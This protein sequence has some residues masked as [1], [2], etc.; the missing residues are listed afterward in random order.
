MVDSQSG[1]KVQVTNAAATVK[2]FASALVRLRDNPGLRMELA[3]AARLRAET[4][5]RWEAKRAVLERTY[6]S[7]IRR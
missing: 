7:L 5:F 6:Q 3:R 2:A 1:I 4:L